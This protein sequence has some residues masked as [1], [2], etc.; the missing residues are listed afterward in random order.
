MKNG[1]RIRVDSLVRGR[2]GFTTRVE[3]VR[4]TSSSPHGYVYGINAEGRQRVIHDP[5]V[6]GDPRPEK[7]R[8][9]IPA[10]LRP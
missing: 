8:R 4:V 5:E 7:E 3:T 9:D 6:I 10:H 2:V 1:E